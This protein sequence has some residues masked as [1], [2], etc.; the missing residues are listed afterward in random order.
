M[1]FKITLLTLTLFASIST[2]LFA[3]KYKIEIDAPSYKNQSAELYQNI[4]SRTGLV[5][6]A[7]VDS[8]GYVCFQDSVSSLAGGEYVLRMNNNVDIALLIED[9]QPIEIKLKID[10]SDITKSTI[11]GS[12]DTEILWAFVKEISPLYEKYGEMQGLLNSESNKGKVTSDDL[13]KLSDQILKVQN[14]YLSKHKGSWFANYVSAQ[15]QV[16][17]ESYVTDGMPDGEIRK[18][19]Q[20]HFFDNVDFNENKL[21]RTGY[22]SQLVDDYLS[23][24]VLQIPDTIAEEACRLVEKCKG[25]PK[26]SEEM[27]RYLFDK[28]YNSTVV[29][30]EN[31]WAK[32][33]ETYLL[34]K[35][36][37][38]LS[39]TGY[40]NLLHAYESLKRNRIGMLA[41]NL[42]VKQMDGTSINTND[43]K[44]DFTVLMF[45]SPTCA[46]CIR[47]VDQLH[48]FLASN[49]DIDLK[50]IAFI[51]NEDEAEWKKFVEEHQIQD[52]VNVSDYKFESEYWLKYDTR[53]TPMIYLLDKNKQILSRRINVDILKQMLNYY[54]K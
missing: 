53:A 1:L 18:I 29:G 33:F 17:F 25:N 31:V 41:E 44:A 2:A 46:H 38:W 14:V 8:V 47:A 42:A 51:L 21:L 6:S 24:I 16:D 27:L 19:Y 54:L 45:Y 30:D 26:A 5:N 23:K 7:I 35:N 40:Y 49:S 4:Y 12:K 15:N 28:T 11:Q 34:D 37:T 36:V 43:V 10:G 20:E 50:V 3:N 32:L 52:W 22:F 13:K 39:P 48:E 9:D